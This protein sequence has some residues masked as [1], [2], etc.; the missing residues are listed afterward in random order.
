MTEK[1]IHVVKV[2]KT[3]NMSFNRPNTEPDRA[4][5]G[6]FSV[7]LFNLCAFWSPGLVHRGDHEKMLTCID[8]ARISMLGLNSVNMGYVRKSG[9]Q[10][11]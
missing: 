7:T 11:S 3:E 4:N 9:R 5:D 6:L 10:K 8:E 1:N 2:T